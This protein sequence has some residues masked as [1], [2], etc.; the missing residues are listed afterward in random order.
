MGG[1]W[2]LFL[3]A[4]IAE[5]AGR[6]ISEF[7]QPSSLAKLAQEQDLKKA[8]QA[9]SLRRLA[10]ADMDIGAYAQALSRLEAAIPLYQSIRYFRQ[11]V[12]CLRLQ[13]EIHYKTD[14]L[15]FAVA[16]YERAIRTLQDNNVEDP[17]LE[18]DCRYNYGFVLYR[19]DRNNQAI[20]AF[21]LAKNLYES[22]RSPRM[23]ASCLKLKAHCYYE[24]E[25]YDLA[26]VVFAQ[27]GERYQAI[28]DD[29]TRGVCAY[30]LGLSYFAQKQYQPSIPSFSEAM[31]LL[32]P[33]APRPNWEIYAKCLKFIANAYFQ[34]EQFEPALR[35]YQQAR[36]SFKTLQSWP[37]EAFC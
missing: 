37:E 10:Y 26:A 11:L 9:D 22:I 28:N 20:E 8:A 30:Y 31:K 23:A 33:A 34:Q 1:F 6:G 4:F 32:Q 18:A 2:C 3:T 14:Q 35:H 27:A 21:D 13:G 16:K 5:A 15:D 25:K 17:K 12:E 7:S 19:A 29:S 24:Q 36:R